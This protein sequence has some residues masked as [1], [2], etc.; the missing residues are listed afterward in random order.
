MLKWFV[1]G[2][3]VILVALTVYCFAIS[4][5][6]QKVVAAVDGPPLLRADIDFSKPSTNEFTFRHTVEPFFGTMHLTLEADPW[7][8]EW[9]E[10]DFSSEALRETKGEMFLYQTNN[11]LI[12][13]APLVWFCTHSTTEPKAAPEQTFFGNFPLGEYRLVIKTKAGLPEELAN[14]N[15]KLVLRYD[16]IKERSLASV[17]KGFSVVFGI[18]ALIMGGT[19]AWLLGRYERR[20]PK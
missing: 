3:F 19:L 15:Q 14:T 16:L 13:N 6:T 2:V 12:R 8:K 11:V 5:A 4:R 1:A 18:G 7:P 9:T 10:R 17:F 20:S